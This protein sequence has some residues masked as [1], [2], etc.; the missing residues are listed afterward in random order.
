MLASALC[1]AVNEI[2]EEDHRAEEEVAPVDGDEEHGSG[3]EGDNRAGDGDDNEPV[4]LPHQDEYGQ[5]GFP[6][7]CDLMTRIR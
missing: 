2:R 4:P 7:L 1:H 6:E 5:Q 3:H